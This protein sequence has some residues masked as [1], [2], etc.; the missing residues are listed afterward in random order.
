MWIPNQVWN[1]EIKFGMTRSEYPLSFQRKLES[2][3]FEGKRISDNRRMTKRK[4]E[5]MALYIQA[6]LMIYEKGC[7]DIRIT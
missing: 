2:T 6:L 1:D 3:I 5:T 4:D 7:G